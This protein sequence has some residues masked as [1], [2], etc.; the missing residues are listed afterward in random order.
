[1]ILDAR[2]GPWRVA[3]S[4][5]RQVNNTLR[6]EVLA[7]FIVFRPEAFWDKQRVENCTG[8]H[9]EEQVKDYC[10]NPLKY[11]RSKIHKEHFNLKKRLDISKLHSLNFSLILSLRI[12]HFRLETL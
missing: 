3:R 6:G 10:N 12:L 8:N 11:P 9:K 1:M 5:I 4:F 7:Q 2:K